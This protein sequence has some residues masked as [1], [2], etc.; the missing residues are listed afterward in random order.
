MSAPELNATAR[1]RKVNLPAII[2]LVAFFAVVLTAL[3]Y[4][5]NFSHAD[6]FGYALLVFA[7]FVIGI[8]A[9]RFKVVDGA[10]NHFFT[11]YFRFIGWMLLSL[12]PLLVFTWLSRYVLANH[13]L[14]Y[15][16]I[17]FVLWGLLLIWALTLIFTEKKRKRFFAKLQA[18]GSF[19]PIVY[20]FNLLM[21]AVIF[22]SSVTFVLAQHGVI[23]LTHPIQSAISHGA[24]TDFYLWHFFDAVPFLE[25]N[26]TLHWDEP[27]TYESGWIGFALLV[28]KI[29]VILP[30]IAAFA[31]YWKQ[32]DGGDKD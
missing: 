8:F 4:W 27:L 13:S 19:T 22:F 24:I 31:W 26:K 23:A 15:Q 3:R 18:L 25:V 32:V 30:V 6:L 12:G 21:I 9:N 17:I 7:I 11:A 14:S 29:L 2:V 10:I 20:A 28:F 16:I 5:F 1:T